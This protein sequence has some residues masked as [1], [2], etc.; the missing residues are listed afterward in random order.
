MNGAEQFGLSFTPWEVVSVSRMCVRIRVLAWVYTRCATPFFSKQSHCRGSLLLPSFLGQSMVLQPFKSADVPHTLLMIKWWHAIA[1]LYRYISGAKSFYYVNF[2]LLLL[3]LGNGIE[4]LHSIS[5]TLLHIPANIYLPHLWGSNRQS[6]EWPYIDLVNITFSK[7]N[8][9]WTLYVQAQVKCEASP[10]AWGKFFIIY[11]N[12]LVFQSFI[13]KSVIPFH[14]RITCCLC[15]N[16]FDTC[17]NCKH[18]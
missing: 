2:L 8:L 5:R 1:R 13:L 11:Q 18:A 7:C 3:S 4:C 10:G 17:G 6:T 15:S 14:D 16:L 9:R 12:F